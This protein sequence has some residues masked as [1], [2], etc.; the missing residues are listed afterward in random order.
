MSDVGWFGRV[1]APQGGPVYAHEFDGVTP[2]D[3]LRQAADALDL[4][5]ADE[6][7]LHMTRWEGDEWS[8]WRHDGHMLEMAWGGKWNDLYPRIR[9]PRVSSR[10]CAIEGGGCAIQEELTRA[11]LEFMRGF[12][13]EDGVTFP[14][15]LA[16]EY[17]LRPSHGEDDDEFLEIRPVA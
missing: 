15:P 2:G 14:L 4:T 8:P 9:C 12:Q 1:R 7:T 17:R 6:V 16:L 13:A 10:L 5:G 3:I 11:G